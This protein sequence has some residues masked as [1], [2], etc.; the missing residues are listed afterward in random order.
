MGSAESSN[1][2]MF[3][4]RIL[5]LTEAVYCI[6]SVKFWSLDALMHVLD[7]LIPYVQ[8]HDLKLSR[9]KIPLCY[10]SF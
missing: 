2:T 4:G 9:L 6:L 8:F 7:V 10:N 5:D 3:Q 1:K